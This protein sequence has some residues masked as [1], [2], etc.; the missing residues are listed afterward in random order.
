MHANGEIRAM[1]FAPATAGATLRIFNHRL[2][3]VIQF[4]A[5]L[6]AKRGTETTLLAPGPVDINVVFLRF[7]SLGSRRLLFCQLD[8]FLFLNKIDG[9][10][11]LFPLTLTLSGASGNSA[12]Y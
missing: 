1:E 4:N 2:A 10:A 9:F 6:G 3:R 8:P 7:G 12:K 11:I 5:T